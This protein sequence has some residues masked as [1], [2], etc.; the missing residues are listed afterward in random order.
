MRSISASSCAALFMLG[1]LATASASAFEPPPIEEFLMPE[2]REIV[3][4]R[5]AAPDRISRDATIL[6]LR[7]TGYAEV[8]RGTNGFVCLVL[9]SWGNP[10]FSEEYEYAPGIIVPECLDRN[11]ARTILPMQLHRAE[12]GL[13]GIAPSEIKQRIQ[14]GFRSGRFQR[15]ETVSFSYMMSAAM[16]LADGSQLPAHVMVYLPDEYTNEI[17]GGFP[18]RDKFVFVEGGP[19][20]PFVA[21]NVYVEDKA[22]EPDFGE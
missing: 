18:Y 9:R 20:E 14:E 3:L 1:A 7:R 13:E 8:S 15:T 2:A 11:A 10:V 12:L 19:D 4:A 6:V 16:T 5:S 17:L 21:V 22:I